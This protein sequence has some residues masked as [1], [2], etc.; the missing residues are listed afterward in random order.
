VSTHLLLEVEHYCDRAPMLVKGR[1]AH[2]DVLS[3]LKDPQRP[4]WTEFE[5]ATAE[6]AQKAAAVWLERGLNEGVARGGEVLRWDV[7]PEAIPDLLMALA[8]RGVA[9]P[10]RVEPVTSSLSDLFTHLARQTGGSIPIPAGE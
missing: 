5:F 10:R 2:S 1:L 7:A 9:L 4:R 6:D 8:G 3:L